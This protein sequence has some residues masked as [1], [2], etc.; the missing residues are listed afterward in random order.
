MIAIISAALAFFVTPAAVGGTVKRLGI[1]AAILAIAGWMIIATSAAHADIIKKFDANVFV[2]PD[3]SLKVTEEITADFD[4]PRHGIKRFIPVRFTRYNNRYTTPL[5]VLQVECDDATAQTEIGDKGSDVNIRIGDPY[6]TIEG[7]HRYVIRYKVSRVVN[8][9]NGHPEIYW[10][11]TGNEWPYPIKH[12]QVTVHLPPGIKKSDVQATSYVGNQGSTTQGVSHVADNSTVTFQSNE[13]SPG[14]GL[15]FAIQVP[16]G[17]IEKPTAIQEVASYLLDWWPLVVLPFGTFAF[18]Y[19]KWQKTGRDPFNVNIAGVDWNPPQGLAPAEVGTLI[20]EHCDTSDI[21]STLVDL[22]ARGYLTIQETKRTGLIFSNTDYLFSKT[23]KAINRSNADSKEEQLKGYE[24][25]F[26]AGLF[27]DGRTSVTMHNL[28][29]KFFP[30]LKTIRAEL[31]GSLYR[32][33]YFP[34]NPETVRLTYYGVA[35]LL[36]VIAWVMMPIG[37]SFSWSGGAVLAAIIIALFAN[38]MP[39]RT[40]KGARACREAVGFKRFVERAEKSRI[41][42]L[43]KDDPTIFGRLLPYAMVLNCAG[44]WVE[45]FEGLLQ[46]P[47]DWYTP[48]G[49]GS[50]NYYFSPTDFMNDFGTGMSS[51]GNTMSTPPSSSSSGAG[52]GFSGFGGGGFSGGGFGGGGGG[53]W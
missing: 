45:K 21:V 31:Y 9:F 27:E 41:E 47:P 1:G 42:V 12:A 2:E 3:G 18:L 34:S 43:A 29:Y 8:F 32:S 38:I 49:Y 39:A 17:A 6:I 14:Q 20:D 13:L 23:E 51:L 50:S 30:Y 25:T 16:E 33:G 37:F 7:E 11:V 36:F 46:Q 48:Y 10:N 44:A 26:L 22:A 4:T 15:T 19:T 52:G 35:C 40:E 24:E 5:K 28:R 53:S